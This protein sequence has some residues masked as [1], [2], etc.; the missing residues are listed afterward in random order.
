M[1]SD[2][3]ENPFQSPA[4]SEG[5]DPKFAST[6]RFAKLGWKISI[7]G[8]GL[9]MC[10]AL[11]LVL[12][13]PLWIFFACVAGVVACSV[14]GLFVTVISTFL[15]TRCPAIVQHVQVGIIINMLIWGA[16]YLAAMFG[17]GSAI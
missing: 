11:A 10:A 12:G 15:I 5:S 13:L 7:C 6:I 14:G 9:V 8:V 1:S 3:P 2:A 17:L 4:D 16:F